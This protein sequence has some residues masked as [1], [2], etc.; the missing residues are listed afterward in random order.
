MTELAE[1]IS[2]GTIDEKIAAMARLEPAH[3]DQI[4]KVVADSAGMRVKTLDEEV[5]KRRKPTTS[6]GLSFIDVEP[7]VE[8]VDGAE[9]L[10]SIVA[11]LRRFLV[12]TQ[13]STD[14][15]ALWLVMTWAVEG[16]FILPM[17]AI[18]SPQKRCGK[19][20]LLILLRKIARKALLVSN[21]SS[22][23]IFRIVEKYQPTLLLDEAETWSKENEELRGILNAGHSRD[24]AMV[25]RVDGDA[26]EPRAFNCFCPKALA[27][28]GRLADT[29]EDR[30]II[31][32]MRRRAPNEAVEQLRQDKLNLDHL[33]RVCARWAADNL[34]TMKDS[35]PIVPPELHDRAADN[36]RPLLRIADLAGGDRPTRA[37]SAATKLTI[38]GNDQDSIQSLLLSD[39]REILK[40]KTYMKSTD[41][42]AA[43][44]AID[45]HPWPEWKHGKPMTAVQLA[46]QLA[47]FN[48]GPKSI[49]VAD[50]LVVKGYETLLFEE[51]FARYLPKDSIPAVTE[52]Q[53]LKNNG[54][55]AKTAVT[56]NSDVTVRPA[57]D[58]HTVTD[59]I[60]QSPEKS[61][62]CNRVTD[63]RPVA[64]TVED[65]E[66]F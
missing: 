43:L 63:H 18:S 15:V 6:P 51:T 17:L 20:T 11:E 59:Q 24:T 33:Q 2:E 41:L 9:L 57:T 16:T 26:L 7:W 45:D 3:Y 38:R 5:A 8:P 39:I 47:P 34:Q 10:D 52:L 56:R 44:T 58:F 30:S 19:S 66:Y 21:T 64:P 46:R 4:R 29:I 27:G 40:A 28:I 35:D 25:L 13:E 61:G 14:A 48:I 54:F 23:A 49:R 60:A 36:W 37:R 31:I 42:V 32:E 65:A 1:I 12:L 53:T 62:V 22:A 55:D 50:H